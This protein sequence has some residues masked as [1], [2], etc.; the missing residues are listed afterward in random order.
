MAVEPLSGNHHL[1]AFDCGNADLNRFIKCH[2]LQSHQG[3]FSKTFV[4]CQQGNH[5][6]GFYTLA[7]GSVKHADA[8]VR[9]KKGASQHDI[10]V[11]LLARLAVCDSAR[12]RKIGS[13]LLKHAML[14]VLDISKRAGVRAMLTHAKDESAKSFYAHFDFEPGP[15][16]DLHMFLLLKDIRKN[17]KPQ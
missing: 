15:T 3:D 7:T 1:D 11:M 16:N 2:A 8:T 14:N 12:G 13:A 4:T 5:V 9:M 6:I 10:P 17:L